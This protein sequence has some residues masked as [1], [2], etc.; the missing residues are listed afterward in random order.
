MTTVTRS[1]D[2]A[3][4]RMER[5]LAFTVRGHNVMLERVI[6]GPV[7]AGGDV[8]IAIGGCGPVMAGG[9]VEIEQG[10]CG[11]VLAGNDFTMH[12][13]GCGPV[14]AGG[15]VTLN[16]ATAFAVLAGRVSID[17]GSNVR[18]AMTAASFGVTGAAAAVGATVGVALGLLLRRHR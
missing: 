11:P 18:V 17:A 7:S 2:G 5:V 9:S 14:M 12:Q 6:A 10:G 4:V 3:E 8:R 16:D 1:I 13:G 15:D